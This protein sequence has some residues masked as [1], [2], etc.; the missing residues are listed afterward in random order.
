MPF[1]AGGP[2]DIIARIVGQRMSELV[3]QPIIIDNRGGQGGALGTDAV[4]KANPDG[5]TIGIVNAGALTI[6]QSMEKV[7]Y[8]AEGFRAGH[9]GRHRAGDAGGREQRSRKEHE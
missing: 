6:N 5:Y 1:P 3:K 4:A 9:P 2:N 7:A 8:D